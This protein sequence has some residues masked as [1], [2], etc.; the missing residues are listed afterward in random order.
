MNKFI[1][2]NNETGKSVL[3]MLHYVNNANDP[4]CPKMQHYLYKW[5]MSMNHPEQDNRFFLN[6]LFT[7]LFVNAIS[8][9]LIEFTRVKSP[10]F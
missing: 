10:N 8:F 3:N 6:Y 2:S 7:N 9:H 5:I 1:F 4:Y